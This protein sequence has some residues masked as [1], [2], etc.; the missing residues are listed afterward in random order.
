MH[1]GFAVAL[2]TLVVLVLGPP[3]EDC[4]AD[5]TCS[6]MVRLQTHARALMTVP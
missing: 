1:Q 5:D 3:L 2:L 6:Q 4:E